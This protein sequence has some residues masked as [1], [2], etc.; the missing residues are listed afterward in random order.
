MVVAGK[1]GGGGNNAQEDGG[2]QRVGTLQLLEGQGLLQLML[3]LLAVLVVALP[4]PN[5]V[6]RQPR[7]HLLVWVMGRRMSLFGRPPCQVV[8][9]QPADSPVAK[10]AD[11]LNLVQRLGM[12]HPVFLVSLLLVLAESFFS[13]LV[14]DLVELNNFLH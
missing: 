4:P 5:M 10:A 8:H 13:Y 12:V 1:G 11:D 9:Q 14:E 2:Q 6:V 3:Q 7:S